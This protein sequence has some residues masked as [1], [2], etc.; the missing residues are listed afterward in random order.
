MERPTPNTACTDCRKAGHFCQ[1]LVF[2]ADEPLCLACADS[3]PCAV[4]KSKPQTKVIRGEE[5]RISPKAVMGPEILDVPNVSQE[6]EKMTN[7][8]NQ[9]LSGNQVPL[10][11]RA[12][13]AR[14]DTGI[15]TRVI[16]EKYKVSEGTVSSIRAKARE[17]AA[18]GQ[19]ATAPTETDQS[20]PKEAVANPVTEHLGRM[21][22]QVN[23]DIETSQEID[24]RLDDLLVSATASS[25]SHSRPSCIPV[26][27]IAL[28]LTEEE[29]NAIFHRLPLEE[30]G[31]A[32]KTVLQSQ[33]V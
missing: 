13:I 11:I 26:V 9:P 19:P 22:D 30:K 27:T 14:E 21:I 23:R 17:L 2:V 33:I 4:T 1:A 12:A 10:A 8:K 6:A 3:E 25:A 28:E 31:A 15:P 7:R 16:A 32:L 24:Q 5:V 18:T 20:A 29:C